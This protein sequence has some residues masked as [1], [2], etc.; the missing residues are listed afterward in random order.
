MHSL[1]LAG[2]DAMRFRWLDAD[3][4]PALPLVVDPLDGLRLGEADCPAGAV[5]LLLGPSYADVATERAAWLARADYAVR[6]A[7]AAA[8]RGTAVAV[9]DRLAG[10]LFDPFRPPYGKDPDAEEAPTWPAG[11]QARVLRPDDD[12]TLI[13]S[14]HRAGLIGLRERADGFTLRPH[15]AWERAFSSG[16]RCADCLHLDA[17]HRRCRQYARAEPERLAPRCAGFGPI[18]PGWRGAEVAGAEYVDLRGMELVEQPWTRLQPGDAGDGGRR[19]G[20]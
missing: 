11:T 16:Q 19:R 2:V 14:L 13:V 20:D 17:V 8:A 18:T 9:Q 12:R 10:V 3:E 6:R 15:A 5:A 1:L 7:A 4:R